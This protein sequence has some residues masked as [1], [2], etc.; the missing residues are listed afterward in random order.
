MLNYD[1]LIRSV[2]CIAAAVT[3]SV[4][5][6]HVVI[7]VDLCIICGWGKFINENMITILYIQYKNNTHY[8]NALY[9]L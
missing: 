7:V 2:L 1:L 9:K 5:R 4:S 8:D 3:I 6:H